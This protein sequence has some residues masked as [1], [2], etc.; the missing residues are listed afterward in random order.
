LLETYAIV[1]TDLETQAQS[2]SG[3]RFR[4]KDA[5]WFADQTNRAHGRACRFRRAYY[6]WSVVRAT[7]Y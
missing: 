2:V 5:Q 6:F 4:R 1:C 7:I 3:Y